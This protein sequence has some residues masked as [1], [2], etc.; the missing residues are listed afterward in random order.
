[1]AMTIAQ[2]LARG[3]HADAKVGGFDVAEMLIE[4]PLIATGNG[5]PQYL[6]VSATADWTDRTVSMRFFSVNAQSQTLAD[7]AIG[8][9]KITPSQEWSTG[10]N[11]MAHLVNNRIAALEQESATK[12]I[13][14]CHRLKRAMAYKLFS[15]FVDYDETYQGMDE[16]IINTAEREATARVVFKVRDRGF[17]FDPC[18]V[19]SLGHI[20]GFVMNNQIDG[21]DEGMVF[22]N[23]GWVSARFAKP[24]VPGGSYTTYN[25]MHLV[26]NQT[27]VGDTYVLEDGIIVGV[28]EGV[29]VCFT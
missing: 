27:Y 21:A 29:K 16:V 10:W 8:T 22:V 11:R 20:A 24:I 9:V 1:M 25:K 13:S 15:S 6:R 26:G 28:I 2:H 7:H 12:D 3:E 17:G 18:W 5:E 4:K 14:V 19:D 23:H